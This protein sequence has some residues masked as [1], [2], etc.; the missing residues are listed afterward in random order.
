M[1]DQKEQHRTAVEDRKEQLSLKP[2]WALERGFQVYIPTGSCRVRQPF[3]VL[4]CDGHLYITVIYHPRPRLPQR[5]AYL[6]WPLRQSTSVIRSLRQSTSVVRSLRQSTSVVRALRQSTSVVR[7]LRQSTSVVRALRH[8]R[9]VFTR[10]DFLE[11]QKPPQDISH[12]L[13]HTLLV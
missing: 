8:H 1:E 2:R 10:K 11:K 13:A 9:S 5:V 6:C 4:S 12:T 7:A 3:M